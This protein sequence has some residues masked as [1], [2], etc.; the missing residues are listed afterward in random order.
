M[1]PTLPF[2]AGLLM[3]G[4]LLAVGCSSS[5]I[6]PSASPVASPRATPSAAA[7]LATAEAQAQGLSQVIYDLTTSAVAWTYEP[8]G[9]VNAERDGS[10]AML[11]LCVEIRGL[12]DRDTKLAFDAVQLY[13]GYKR[14]CAEARR[15]GQ[16]PPV[17][18]SYERNAYKHVQVLPI[19][20]KCVVEQGGG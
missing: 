7:S 6:S 18:V 13:V 16:P 11:L 20:K 8:K 2:L 19:A 10:G 17:D 9:D 14:A 12:R 3:M 15:D 4:A 5:K 1:R